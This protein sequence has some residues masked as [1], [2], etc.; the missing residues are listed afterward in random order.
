[1]VYN[2]TMNY[3]D[4][5]LPRS[6]IAVILL[7]SLWASSMHDLRHADEIASDELG[8][9]QIVLSLDGDHSDDPREQSMLLSGALCIPFV[10]L[11]TCYTQQLISVAPA[12]SLSPPYRPPAKSA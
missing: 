9:S 11:Q 3:H 2:E 12:N 7:F 5:I 1:M 8:S 6:C 10:S 4:S